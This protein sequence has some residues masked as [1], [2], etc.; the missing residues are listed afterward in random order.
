VVI[1]EP[2]R[3]YTRDRVTADRS[4]RHV[5]SPSAGAAVHRYPRAVRHPALMTYEVVLSRPFNAFVR[6]ARPLWCLAELGSRLDRGS[7]GKSAKSSVVEAV[8]D[9]RTNEWTCRP[10]SPSRFQLVPAMLA[11]AVLVSSDPAPPSGYGRL[12]T[13]AAG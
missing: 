4:R 7:V 10:M 12:L 1:G 2:P 8:F 3:E 9:V 11:V 6:A 5:S 13:S